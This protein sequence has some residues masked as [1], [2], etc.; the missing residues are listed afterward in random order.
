VSSSGS[1]PTTRFSDRVADYVRARPRYPRELIPLLQNRTGL[2]PAWV[3]ADIGSGTGISAEPF[4]DFG[5][6][7][8]GVEPNAEMRAAGERVLAGH[9]TFHSVA[10]S[11]EDTTLAAHSID[12][13]TAGQAFHWFDRAGA[14]AEFERILKP[15]GW[16]V[17]F[18]NRRDVASSPF[19]R[20]YEALLLRYGTDYQQVRHDN[21]GDDDIAGFLGP[22]FQR[23]A[24]P[25]SQ[26]LDLEGLR[27]RLLSSSYTPGAG[28]LRRAALLDEL[29]KLFEQYQEGGSIT[30]DYT[31][32]IFLARL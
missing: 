16:I 20:E 6:I 30:I 12:L 10:G 24:L 4:L 22:D 9:A 15:S 25:N 5:N 14:R 17:V 13:I 11:A 28:D 18:W 27:A 32:D 23:A 21:L 8:Y 19:A 3:V 1:N 31:T 26:V 29:R 7:V 2:T